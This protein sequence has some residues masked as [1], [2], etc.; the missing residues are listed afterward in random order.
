IQDTFKANLPSVRVKASGTVIVFADPELFRKQE[1][2]SSLRQLCRFGFTRA[3]FESSGGGTLA[4]AQEFDLDSPVAAN[5][6][7]AAVTV[8]TKEAMGNQVGAEPPSQTEV[9]SSQ[10]AKAK[11]TPETAKKAN[12]LGEFKRQF[13][14]KQV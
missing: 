9:A 4:P 11:P 10:A 5:P 1:D 8:S 3:R 7:S 13:L 6:K 12:T 2:Q 14:N